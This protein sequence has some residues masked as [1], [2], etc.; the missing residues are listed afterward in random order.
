MSI[1]TVQ[2]LITAGVAIGIPS[3]KVI[4][5]TG[6]EAEWPDTRPGLTGLL[7]P[8]FAEHFL[9]AS[10]VEEFIDALESGGTDA[11]GKV[12]GIKL[13]GDTKFAHTEMTRRGAPGTTSSDSLKTKDERDSD[14][15]KADGKAKKAAKDA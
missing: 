14:S 1:I 11:D 6:D 5:I 15:D 8:R 10:A 12:D 3:G 13:E 4:G 2:Q 9:P 7:Q